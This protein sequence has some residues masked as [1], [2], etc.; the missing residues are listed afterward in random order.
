MNSGIILMAGKGERSKLNYN[1]ALYQYMG[2]PLFMH[3]VIAFYN[4]EAINDVYLVIDEN[5]LVEV[6]KYIQ[7]YDN[8]KI[9]AGGQTRSE[10]LRKALKEINADKVVV[11]DAARPSI[12]SSDITRILKALDENDL[13]TLYHKV[14]DTIKDG[15]KTLNRDNLKAVTTPQGFTKKCFEKILNNQ[16]NVYDELQIFENDNF[17]IGFVEEEHENK[18]LTNQEDFEDNKYLIGHSLDFHP[19]VGDRK[20][21][22]GGITFDY[23]KGLK[24][25]SDADV[26]YHA[27]AEAIIGALNL[28]DLGTLF[29]DNDDKYKD[30]DSSYFLQYMKQVL[31]EKQYKINNIDI[32]IYAEKPNF[33][34]HKRLMAN[35]IALNLE[36]SSDIVNV[37]ATTMEKQGVIG[38]GFGIA[39]EAI[40]LLKNVK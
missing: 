34:N 29:P 16:E 3:S 8:I 30:I 12:T 17:K 20:L 24:G 19:L 36:I 5:D 31:E 27:V 9:V 18:K 10:S 28:G 26:V 23:P 11:H 33:K 15:I 7:D 40:V 37:K 38:N 22:L 13:A 21:V 4:N 14:V 25:H 1:K 6:T 39:S 32:I 35:N 2:K